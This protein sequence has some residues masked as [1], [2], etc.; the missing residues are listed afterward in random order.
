MLADGEELDSIDHLA[1]HLACQCIVCLIDYLHSAQPLAD[2]KY[3]SWV[4]LRSSG[5]IEV[6]REANCSAKTIYGEDHTG[7]FVDSFHSV[8]DAN[9]TSHFHHWIE[10]PNGPFIGDPKDHS[11]A[12]CPSWDSAA[13]ISNVDA[14]RASLK[15]LDWQRV[16]LEA[17]THGEAETAIRRCVYR[18]KLTERIKRWILLGFYTPT[19]D[20]LNIHGLKRAVDLHGVEFLAN[21]GHRRFCDAIR[22]KVGRSLRAA[23]TESV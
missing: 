20:R 13:A 21:V 18:R 14:Y 5:K 16:R 1:T 15:S 12:F 3:S 4:W 9:P 10:D 2:K 11:Y 7:V 8:P 22:T 6:V 19:L 17:Y 23:Q